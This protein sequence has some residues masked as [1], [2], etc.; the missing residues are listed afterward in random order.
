MK[1]M[2]YRGPYRV[3]V[4]EKDEPRIEHPNDAVVRMTK[5]SICGSDLHLYHGMMPDTRI[6][7]TFGH[8]FIGVVEQVGPSVQRLQR[9]DRVMVP[10]NIYCGSCWFCARGLYS[11]CHNVNPNAT[12]VGGIY[13]YSHT[14][15]GYDG[16]QA[17]L[18]RVPF[19][20][21]GPSVIP[22]WM[23]DEDALM[24]TDACSTGYFGAQLGDIVEGDTV[25]VLG[26][27]PVGLYAAKSAWFMGAGRV[28]V[29]DHL[30][31]RLERA[32]TFAHAETYNFAE[33]DDIVVHMKKITDH[34]GADVAIDCVG[35]EA[36]GNL[37]QHIAAAKFTLQGG[38][39]TAL[40]W[41]IDSVRKGG[42]VSVMGAY[43][44]IFSAVKFGDALNK[45]LTLRMNQAPVKR[46]WPRLFEHIR[47]GHLKPS[48]L[49]THRIPLEHIA[50]GY[51]MF[52]AKLD[53]CMKI[54]V[55]PDAA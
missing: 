10:F 8:E 32:R 43:G 21:V 47:N 13:G 31:Y 53:D 25:L 41:A 3:R 7:H 28:I 55:V 17:E 12:A 24:L 1:A 29:I 51:H 44:P 49:I 48:E 22:E 50:E 26:A 54:V 15:G 27:G 20:D 19:A 37:T 52:S 46:Q 11:N 35:A 45:G 30:D 39:P 5:A 34:L 14:T 2:T 42:T 40:N 38:S 16:G 36:D 23:D 9:G 4:Q 33:Y 6:G 18:V